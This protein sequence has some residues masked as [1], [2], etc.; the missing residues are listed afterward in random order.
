METKTSI[1][2]INAAMLRLFHLHKRA[3]REFN[4]SIRKYKY[5]FAIYPE[6]KKSNINEKT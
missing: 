2:K 5:I 1:Y 4:F 3:T 6:S